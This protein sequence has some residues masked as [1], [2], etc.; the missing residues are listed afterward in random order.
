MRKICNANW[1]FVTILTAVYCTVAVNPVWAKWAQQD[2]LIGTDTN[3][4]DHFGCAVAVDGNTC[5]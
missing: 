1:I 4:G 5:L 2:N 3:S